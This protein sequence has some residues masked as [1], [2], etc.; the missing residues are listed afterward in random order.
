MLWVT[1]SSG[2]PSDSDRIPRIRSATSL[3]ARLDAER[4]LRLR[5]HPLRLTGL[6]AA[7]LIHL[8]CFVNPPQ[9]LAIRLLGLGVV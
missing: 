3:P 8:V 6:V 9:A 5:G 1:S 2:A 4:I 7:L